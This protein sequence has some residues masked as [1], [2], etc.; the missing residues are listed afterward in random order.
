M[1]NTDKTILA[2]VLGTLTGTLTGLLLAPESGE[3]IR[4]KIN[5]TA[6]DVLYDMEDAWEV[7]ADKAR[8]F[9]DTAMH[10]LGV[11]RKK[12]SESLPKN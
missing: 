9:T 4:R 6:N 8:D 7:N 1:D 2:F 11:Y 3:Q 5:R 10:E 12:L